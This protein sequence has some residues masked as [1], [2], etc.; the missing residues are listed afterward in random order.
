MSKI[1]IFSSDKLRIFLLICHL[2]FLAP[3]FAELWYDF[4]APSHANTGFKNLVFF[5]LKVGL[6]LQ[7]ALDFRF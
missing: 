6:F 4:L 3:A 5:Y 2:A 1:V 7:L